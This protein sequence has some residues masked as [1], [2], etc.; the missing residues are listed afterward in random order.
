MSTI[1]G[2]LQNNYDHLPLI[3]LPEYDIRERI[4]TYQ[5][6]ANELIEIN[7][8]LNLIKKSNKLYLSRIINSSKDE[9]RYVESDRSAM[10]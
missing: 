10:T 4:D 1:K 5:V 9:E 7:T 8:E 3:K 6:M 2:N